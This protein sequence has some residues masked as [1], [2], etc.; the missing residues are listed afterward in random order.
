MPDVIVVGAGHNGL[1]AAALLARRGLKVTVLEEKEVVGGASRTEYPFRSAPKLGVSTGA[2]L[3]GLMPPELMRELEL[4]LPLKRRDPHYFLPTLEKRYLLFGSNE[5]EMRTQFL[6]FFSEADWKAN[7]AM[8]AELAAMRDDLAPAW[9]Q[10]PLS[11]EETAERFIRPE[12]RTHFIRLCRG[13]AHEYLDRF[14][15]ESDLLKAMYAV[16]DAFSGLDAGYDTPGAGMNLLV[17]NMCRLPGSG[18]TWMIVGGGMGTVTQSLARLVQKHGG[19][20]RTRAKVAS[21]RTDGGVVKGVVLESGEELSASVV[22]SNADPFRTLKLVEA[23][24]V[25][26]AYR[27]RVNGMATQGTTLKVNLCLKG[28]PTFTCLPEDRGQFGPTIHLLP[29]EDVLESLAKA[30]ADTK[31]G[32][33]A[34]FP[35]M[36][37]YFHTPIDP[38]L[39]DEQGHH[40]SAL[41]VQWV[42]YQPKGSTWEKEESRYVQHLLSI[43]DRFA[44]GTSDLVVETFA[45]PPPKIESHFGITHGHIHH[46]DNK[47]GFNERLPYETPVQGLYFCSAGCHPAGSVIGA[48]GHNAAGVVLKALGR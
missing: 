25:P 32:K 47:L 39:R 22:V 28:L 44:P 21:I 30:Y 48:A 13:T 41:F 9:L 8:N 17:H 34:E 45:L 11:L 12:L 6:A 15:F 23:S 3:L 4:E 20:I 7:Q 42:P 19:E 46:V 10:P 36:E 37:W 29:Q 18:G 27:Q 16:T 14:G 33:L 31:A 26:A 1:V 24:A 35:S 2:Y 40:N 43:C 5:K 38:S